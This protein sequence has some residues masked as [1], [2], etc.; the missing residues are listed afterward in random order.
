MRLMRYIQ[1]IVAAALFCAAGA[2][3]GQNIAGNEVGIFPTAA[4]L[5]GAERILADQNAH[6]VNLTPAQIGQYLGIPGGLSFPLPVLLG[7][8]GASNGTAGLLNLLPTPLIAQDCLQVNTSGN[9][10]LWATCATGGGGSF[11]VNG[12]GL[13]SSSIVNFQN[14]SALNGLTLSF[15]NPSA[16]NVQL[17]L[18]GVLT[19]PGGGTGLSAVPSNGQ[20]P[21]GNGAGYT[22]SALTAGANVTITNG[23]GGVTIA[24]VGSGSG[25]VSPGTTG[26]VAFY[27]SSGTTV[28]GESLPALNTALIAAT[29]TTCADSPGAGPIVAYNPSCWGTTVGVLNV[30]PA[31]GGTTIC[32]LVAGSD[33]QNVLVKNVGTSPIFITNECSSD[34]TVQNRFDMEANFM[35]GPGGLASITAVTATARW[36]LL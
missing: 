8:I 6:T 33:K 9:G 2:S 27:A 17:G 5:N 26:Q 10:V 19:A 14:S 3:F 30:T 28:S 35:I 13:T 12:V 1:A 36:N 32:S 34:S 18:S 7:G 15:S 24:A 4:P 16:G 21:I 23:V 22:L 31:S 29:Q 25:T 20:I 11:Q